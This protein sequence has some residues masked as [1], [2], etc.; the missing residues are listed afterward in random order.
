METK[1][2]DVREDLDLSEVIDKKE[3]SMAK[4]EQSARR[5]AERELGELNAGEKRKRVNEKVQEE[6]REHLSWLMRTLTGIVKAKPLK[7]KKHKCVFR[8]DEGAAE[9]NAKWLRYYRWDLEEAIR[10][11]KDTMVHPG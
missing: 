6:T 4:T 2:F 8:D 9:T 1:G 10:R 5:R 7:V 11:Q 3:S